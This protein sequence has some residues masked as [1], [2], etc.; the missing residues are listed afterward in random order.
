MAAVAALR[1][2]RSDSLSLE[3][4]SL[5]KRSRRAQVGYF[6]LA[7]D[8]PIGFSR[9]GSC[10]FLRQSTRRRRIARAS[11][12]D[13]TVGQRSCLLRCSLLDDEDAEDFRRP[14]AAGLIEDHDPAV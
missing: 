3:F 6:G 1:I 11:S 12:R 7:S 13:A 10:T 14:E 4:V 2:T 8:A 9:S 5:D